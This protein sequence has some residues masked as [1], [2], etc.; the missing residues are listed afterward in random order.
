MKTGNMLWAII[1][2]VS[3]GLLIGGAV[4]GGLLDASFENN[5][6][7]IIA[8]F[9]GILSVVLGIV[10]FLGEGKY[11]RKIGISMGISGVLAAFIAALLVVT[12]V[13]VLVSPYGLNMFN[14]GGPSEPEVVGDRLI[15]DLPIKFIVYNKYSGSA[16]SPTA[17]K[18]YDAEGRV[19]ETL[20][21]SSGVATTAFPYRSQ[22]SLYVYIQ[23]GS[24]FYFTTVVVP[25]YDKDVAQATQPTQHLVRVDAVDIP[26]TL[27]VKL[28]DYLGDLITTEYNISSTSSLTIS[29]VNNEADTALP[30][31]FY[32]PI[33][34]TQYIAGVVIKITGST[35]NVPLITGATPIYSGNGIAVYYVPLNELAALT[36]QRT[37]SVLPATQAI[38]LSIDPTGLAG[39]SYTVTVTAYVDLDLDYMQRAA[40]TPNTDAVSLG[41]ASFTLNV[42]SS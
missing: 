34:E 25:D 37:G 5:G 1:L 9:A 17:L 31:S 27:S 10:I 33:T 12:I 40:G 13:V 42:E 35:T 6:A 16:F 29:I 2:W 11:V 21:V 26:S 23:D 18:L 30:T 14:I 4:H 20:S 3:G 28:Y 41:T 15:L 39:N 19:L 36:D 8:G 32:N 38:A 22:E 24:A 7:A